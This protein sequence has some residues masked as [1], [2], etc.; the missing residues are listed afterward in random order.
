MESLESQEHFDP[1]GRSIFLTNLASA[2]VRRYTLKMEKDPGSSS[3]ELEDDLDSAIRI[4]KEAQ[5]SGPNN[6]NQLG[7]LANALFLRYENKKD[8]QDLELSI[9]TFQTAVEQ[10]S[11]E[12]KAQTL[13]YLGMALHA[14]ADVTQSN[15]DMDLAIQIFERGAKCLDSPPFYRIL[16]AEYGG[17]LCLSRDAIQASQLFELVIELLP[18]IS[19]RF[20]GR[21]D[22]QHNLSVFDGAVW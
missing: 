11:V 13:Y 15:E 9:S 10:Q 22:Q 8:L 21:F 14:K 18:T 3:E 12:F 16:A 4:Y 7:S 19:P 2:F 5:D 1:A 6:Y 20:L 17:G